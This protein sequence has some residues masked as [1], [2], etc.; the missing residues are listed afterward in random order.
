MLQQ[1]F[2]L[3]VTRAVKHTPYAMRKSVHFEMEEKFRAVYER[4]WA[5]R[6]RHHGDIVADQLFHYY[7]QIVGKAVAGSIT[8]RY[9]NIR[10]QNYRWVLRETLRQRNRSTLCLNDA[11]A[12]DVEPLSDEEVMRFLNSYYPVTSTFEN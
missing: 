1:E 11:P 10:D 6:F 2:G 9:I 5:S 8:Y 12:D 7:S 3:T 4:T